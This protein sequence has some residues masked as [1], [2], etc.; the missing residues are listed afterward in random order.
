A[1]EPKK[2]AADLKTLG[3]ETAI[4]P[5]FPL[6]DRFGGPRA[7]EGIVAYLKRV[8]EGLTADDWKATAALLNAKAGPL[9]AEGIKVG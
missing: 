5:M 6:P 1:D 8:A 7:G 2:L 3:C 9:A 4:L